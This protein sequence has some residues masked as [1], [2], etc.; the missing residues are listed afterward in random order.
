MEKSGNTKII[1]HLFNPDISIILSELES[2]TKESSFLENKLCISQQEIKTRLQYLA[3][4][5]IVQISS[6][7]LSYGVDSG[8][9]AKIMESDEHYKG[10]IDGLTE[11]DSYLN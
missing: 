5:G 7:P 10:V 6:N 11:L 9:I 1:E 4:V 2:G 8:K 3:D